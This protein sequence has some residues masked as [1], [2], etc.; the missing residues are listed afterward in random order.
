MKIKKYFIKYI[1]IK[2]KTNID[3]INSCFIAAFYL[4]VYRKS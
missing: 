4:E 3:D 2:G 1:K